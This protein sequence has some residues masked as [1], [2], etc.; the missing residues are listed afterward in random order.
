MPNMLKPVVAGVV[1]VIGY[2]AYWAIRNE[3]LRGSKKVPLSGKPE[4]EVYGTPVAP[5]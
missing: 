5:I 4:P 1:L 3:G 2:L